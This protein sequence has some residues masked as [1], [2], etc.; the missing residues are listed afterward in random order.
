MSEV[1]EAAGHT[2]GGLVAF[3]FLSLAVLILE[4]GIKFSN[5]ML[6]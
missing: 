5:Y 4:N 1:H 6:K 3:S 2:F